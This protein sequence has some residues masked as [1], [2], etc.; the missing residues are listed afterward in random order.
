M[1]AL[2]AFSAMRR[3]SR[4]PGKYEP[5]LNFGMRSLTVRARV[6]QSRHGSH[7]AG[8]SGVATSPPGSASGR[9]HLRL[10]QLL[11]RKTD[12]LSQQICIRALFHKRAQVHPVVGHRWSFRSGVGV[13]KQTL[14]ESADD[15][16]ATQ[17]HRSR[18]ATRIAKPSSRS[19]RTC[20]GMWVAR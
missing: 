16:R 20:C 19:S 15:H 6:S 5:F 13:D 12:Y 14:L 1:T 11:G 4:K 10:H 9:G 7:C 2:S 17:L 3:G 8:L 18:D